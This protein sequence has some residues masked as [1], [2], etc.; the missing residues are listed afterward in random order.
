MEYK[1][2]TCMMT[3]SD[4]WNNSPKALE[5]EVNKLIMEGFEPYGPLSITSSMNTV[6]PGQFPVAALVYAQALIKK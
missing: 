1:V 3:W 2:V 5:E 4:N 6:I